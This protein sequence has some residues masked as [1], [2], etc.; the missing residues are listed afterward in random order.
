MSGVILAET[1][2]GF[3]GLIWLAETFCGKQCMAEG[4]LQVLSVMGHVRVNCSRKAQENKAQLKKLSCL[5][6]SVN[7]VTQRSNR[8]GFSN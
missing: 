5:L 3:Q 2:Y 1:V 4:R 6:V 8:E 7:K